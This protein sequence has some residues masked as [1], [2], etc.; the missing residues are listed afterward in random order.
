MTAKSSLSGGL[1][2]AS[3]TIDRPLRAGKIWV[4]H[5]ILLSDDGTLLTWHPNGFLGK[6]MLRAV[7]PGPRL[8]EDFVELADRTPEEILR[9]A[10]RWG[11]LELCDHDQPAC[12]AHLQCVPRGTGTR[13]L[14][15]V[16]CWYKYAALFG[17]LLRIA[18]NLAD[19][20]PGLDAD[21]EIVINAL[22]QVQ[23]PFYQRRGLGPDLDKLQVILNSLISMSG[24]KPFLFRERGKWSVNFSGGFVIAC[25]LFGALVCRLMLAATCTQGLG[26]C[27]ACGRGYLPSRRPNPNRRSYCDTCRRDKIPVRDAQRDRRARLLRF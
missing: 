5:D 15:P 26:V 25:G 13:Y 8:L 7:Q 17:S 22:D 11:V 3:P 9:Y 12:H 10:R 6:P 18:S 27:S 23:N 2:A 1:N 14:E 19:E 24:V 21:W 16:S 4:P 20:R